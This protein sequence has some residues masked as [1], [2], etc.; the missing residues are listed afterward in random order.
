M[1]LAAEST[2][3][4]VFSLRKLGKEGGETS[5]QP[6]SPLEQL[7]HNT[8]PKEKGGLYSSAAVLSRLS[9]YI[10]QPENGA[11]VLTAPSSADTHLIQDFLSMGL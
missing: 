1:S 6:P 7:S 9:Q 4:W 5:T 3:E 10:A 8:E 2:P 11:S